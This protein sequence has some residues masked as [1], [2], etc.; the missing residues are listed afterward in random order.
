M[1]K[2]A[3]QKEVNRQ[4]RKSHPNMT[5]AKQRPLLRF[6]WLLGEMKNG[7]TPEV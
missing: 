6:R 5:A 4:V 3:E 7:D 2:F 1:A